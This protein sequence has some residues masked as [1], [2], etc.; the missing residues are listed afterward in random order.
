MSPIEQ[1][2]VDKL[3]DEYDEAVK[4][5]K[6]L[7][8]SSQEDFLKS[9]EKLDSA[10][11]NFVVAIESAIDI[12]NH[13]IA[14]QKLRSP[15][16]YAETFQIVGSAGAFPPDFVKTL[17][18]MAKFRNLLVHLYGEVDDERVYKIL[19][20]NLGDFDRLKKHLQK[21]LKTLD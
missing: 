18:D 16:D 5:L 8:K 10:K 11:Y 2:K 19:K 20:K 13:I 3:F 12:C 7:R 1:K 9:F 6:A 14:V 4:K 21:Y 17:K 15:E